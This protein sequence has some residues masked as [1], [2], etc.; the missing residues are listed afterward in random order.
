M[1]NSGGRG[2]GRGRSMNAGRGFSGE[3]GAGGRGR[4]GFN[5]GPGHFFGQGGAAKSGQG[6]KRPLDVVNPTKWIEEYDKELPQQILDMCD[7]VNCALCGV[8]LNGPAVAKSHYEG[9]NH[10]RKVQQALQDLY[11]DPD[12]APKRIKTESEA[13]KP[14]KVKAPK[15]AT[16]EVD[17][18]VYFCEVCNMP[19]TSKLVFDSHLAG[20]THASR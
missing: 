4:G 14:P 12:M 16:D 19:C 17:D 15:A 2:G 10:E 7:P 18:T 5:R 1:A 20:K 6:V 3:R 13:E 8:P 11:P 9:R